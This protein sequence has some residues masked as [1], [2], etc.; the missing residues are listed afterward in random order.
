MGQ[1]LTVLRGGERVTIA[2]ADYNPETDTLWTAPTPAPV[3]LGISPALALINGK[4]VVRD[5]AIIPTLGQ[6]AVELILARRPEGGYESRAQVWEL[7]P[8]VLGGRMKVDP[9]V[10]AAWGSEPA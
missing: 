7:C 10:V 4:S 3:A 5:I 2:T 9:D 1:S 8:E 6:A